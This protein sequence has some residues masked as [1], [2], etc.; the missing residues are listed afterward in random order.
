MTPV[1]KFV[2]VS[3]S[4]ELVELPDV[5][6]VGAPGNDNW[7]EAV[8]WSQRV[9]RLAKPKAVNGKAM[10]RLERAV[11]ARAE[12][13]ETPL[14]WG[15]PLLPAIEADKLGR[16][17]LGRLDVSGDCEFPVVIRFRVD[18]HKSL[19]IGDL[20]DCEVSARCRRC[21]CCAAYKSRQWTERS[22][23]EFALMRDAV[24]VTLTVSP[25]WL[26]EA[27][28][29]IDA[30]WC[31]SVSITPGQRRLFLARALNVETARFRRTLRDR[32]IRQPCELRY[33]QVFEFGEKRGRV[34][35]HLLLLG[36]A[37]PREVVRE[38]WL[39]RSPTRKR[40]RL[41]EVGEWRRIDS[42]RAER[43][44]CGVFKIGF[45]DVKRVFRRDTHGDVPREA[46]SAIRYVAKYIGKTNCR[47]YSSRFFG[48]PRQ[49]AE[50]EARQEIKRRFLESFGKPGLDGEAKRRHRSQA[51]AI[52]SSTLQW[53]ERLGL[54][55]PGPGG[56]PD[57]S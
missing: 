2:Q 5:P 47:V 20:T 7:R 33:F 15:L 48:R 25:R 6:W 26:S 35:V 57:G 10:L 27:N 40:F 28:L 11:Y 16:P 53:I 39:C 14:A 9:G 12:R 24:L 43:A 19:P 52:A 34:H 31:G 13:R 49:R 3:R 38:A 18:P 51:A 44:R 8:A 56:G 30:A 22:I 4:G 46:M 32:S 45:V 42:A 23:I 37:I 17:F 21:P 50:F 54:G 55:P 41:R 36:R 1:S 29:K